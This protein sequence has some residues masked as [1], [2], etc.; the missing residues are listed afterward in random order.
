MINE[1]N[2]KESSC[3]SFIKYNVSKYITMISPKLAI[4]MATIAVVGAGA[5]PM[6]PMALAQDEDSQSVEIERNNEIEQEI[7]Q[8]QEACTN[9][10]QVE[11]SDDDVIDIGGENE[12]EVEQENN[13]IVDQDQSAANV[14]S[15]DDDSINVFDVEQFLASLNL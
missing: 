6:A 2:K 13:C 3:K 7:K 8:K 10:A 11:L 12:A 9:E 5:I 4:L 15:I 1:I 14:A